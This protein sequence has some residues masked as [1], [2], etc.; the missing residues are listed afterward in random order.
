MKPKIFIFIIL[1]SFSLV[2]CK[3]KDGK[4]EI[5]TNQDTTFK[6][7]YTTQLTY[8]KT[9]LGGCNLK[10]SLKTEKVV[11]NDTVIISTKNDSISVFVQLKYNCCAPFITD[12]QI[13]SDSIIMSIKDTC[14]LSTCHCRCLCFY[15]FNFKF[16]QS[17]KNNY[18]YKIVLFDPGEIRS[19]IIKT[20]TIMTK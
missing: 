7:S 19:T 13:K 2:L 9:E 11:Q 1:A 20:G 17:V 12:C 8:I 4:V 18:N 6:E 10:S 5:K 14:S 16:L 3:K 15:T